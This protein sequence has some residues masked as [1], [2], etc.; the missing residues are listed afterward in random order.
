MATTTRAAAHVGGLQHE[1]RLCDLT[2]PLCLACTAPR[3]YS[4]SQIDDLNNVD[5]GR[6]GE[7]LGPSMALSLVCWLALAEWIRI[8]CQ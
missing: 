2:E 1:V 4:Y 3:A 5:D 8:I 7:W 6:D